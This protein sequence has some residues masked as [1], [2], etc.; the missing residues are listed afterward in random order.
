MWQLV[1][2]AAV[3]DIWANNLNSPCQSAS[4]KNQHKCWW[5]RHRGTLY[6]TLVQHTLQQPNN[7]ERSREN[8]PPR[9]VQWRSGQEL[10][11]EVTLELLHYSYFFINYDYL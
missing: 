8:L 3:S 7:R 10:A 1:D 6:S 11:T 2:S 9:N 5:E 4:D